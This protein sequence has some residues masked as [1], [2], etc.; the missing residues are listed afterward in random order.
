M[1]R[2]KTNGMTWSLNVSK[3][4]MVQWHQRNSVSIID[5]TKANLT[6]R[7]LGPGFNQF[8]N[9][10]N[11][12]EESGESPDEGKPETKKPRSQQEEDE[13][14]AN[15]KNGEDRRK[16]FSSKKKPG[17]IIHLG[18]GSELFTD[19][20]VGEEDEEDDDDDEHDA[21]HPKNIGEISS[22]DE[23]E[24]EE[25]EPDTMQVD[26]FKS[27]TAS[28]STTLDTSAA[29]APETRHKSPSPVY[30]APQSPSQR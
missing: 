13:G 10:N 23:E 30:G 9:W 14:W 7:F 12:N 3:I 17:R 11:Q 26:G 6:A 22:S 24:S 27:G 2:P 5:I 29:K 8:Q 21:Y 4:K 19:R 15:W 16:R 1:V 20:N 28:K 25:E 18:D